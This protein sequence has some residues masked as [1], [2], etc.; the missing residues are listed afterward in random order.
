MKFFRY[1]IHSAP[2]LTSKVTSVFLVDDMSPK[3]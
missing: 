3:H 1:L 2:V